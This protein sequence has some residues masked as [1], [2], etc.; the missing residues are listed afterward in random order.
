[1]KVT[2]VRPVEI[3]VDGASC[4]LRCEGWTLGMCRVFR[5]ADGKPR[6][7]RHDGGKYGARIRCQ[8]CLDAVLEALVKAVK[9]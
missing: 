7:L 6:F 8:Q 4:G 2:V 5:R 3:D 1:M 9:K